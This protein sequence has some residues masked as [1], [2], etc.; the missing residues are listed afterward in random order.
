MTSETKP[1]RLSAVGAIYNVAASTIVE[2]LVSKGVEIENNPNAKVQPSRIPK[3]QRR[4]R[5]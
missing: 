2:Y 3:R 5:S 4:T 1:K